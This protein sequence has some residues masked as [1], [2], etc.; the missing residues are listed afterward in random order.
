MASCLPWQVLLFF[1]REITG[2]NGVCARLHEVR[3]RL[4]RPCDRSIV[5]L[6][7]ALFP[8][9]WIQLGVGLAV[10]Q[11]AGP[12][13]SVVVAWIVRMHGGFGGLLWIADKP[14]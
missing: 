3:E 1:F 7:T 11:Y 13:H 14:A 2:H 10:P 4:L 12:G 6:G 5:A 8:S 9:V